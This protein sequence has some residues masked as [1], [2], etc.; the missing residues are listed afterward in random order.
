MSHSFDR[1]CVDA[2]EILLEEIRSHLH[3]DETPPFPKQYSILAV[4]GRGGMG[5]V[6]RA[7]DSTLGR[8]VAL[9]TI[10]TEHRNR[11][12]TQKRFQ[13][14]QQLLAQLAIPG[15]PQ[16]HLTGKTEDH[17][18]FYSMELIQGPTFADVLTDQPFEISLERFISFAR[19]MALVHRQKIAHGDLKPNNLMVTEHGEMRVM[20]W[21]L[22]RN[23]KEPEDN[24]T[25]PDNKR[26][27]SNHGLMGTFSY[28]APEQARGHCHM[29]LS[30][31]VF[32]MGA[33]L[34]EL[35][36]GAPLYASSNR[37]NVLEM[38][39]KG[40]TS[41]MQEKLSGCNAEPGLIQLARKSIEFDPSSRPADAVQFFEELNSVIRQI[42]EK[43]RTAEQELV[44]IEK[45]FELF[46]ANRKFHR[47]LAIAGG[48]A[49]LA[50]M[51]V[52]VGWGA[53]ERNQR[54]VE[55]GL[56]EKAKKSERRAIEGEEH[57]NQSFQNARK[58]YEE[59]ILAASEVY[60]LLDD[61]L[62]ANSKQ[63]DEIRGPVYQIG[64]SLFTDFETT[65]DSHPTSYRKYLLRAR[66]AF[67]NWRLGNTETA[68]EELSQVIR[69]MQ[70]IESPLE[71][72]AFYGA[73][74]D[75]LLDTATCYLELELTDHFESN[76]IAALRYAPKLDSPPLAEARVRHAY[77]MGLFS[78][79][80]MVEAERQLVEAKACL[81]RL[82]KSALKLQ[83]LMYASVL[84][85][86]GAVQEEIGKR[87]ESV[88]YLQKSVE[89]LNGVRQSSISSMRALS[90]A[91]NSLGIYY[92]KSG[93]PQKSSWHF[94][95]A[96]DIREDSITFASDENLNDLA[97]DFNNLGTA[98]VGVDRE[99][100]RQQFAY[101]IRIQR[102]VLHRN[103]NSAKFKETMAR[104]LFNLGDSYGADDQPEKALSDYESA[105]LYVQKNSSSAES[106]R[107]FANILIGEAI[108]FRKLKKTDSARAN[109]LQAIQVLQGLHRPL[110]AGNAYADDLAMAHF[111]LCILEKVTGNLEDAIRHCESAISVWGEFDTD[112]PSI[113]PK[114]NRGE[115]YLRALKRAIQQIKS[116]LSASESFNAHE[117]ARNFSA[118]CNPRKPIDSVR[119]FAK[120]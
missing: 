33:I 100:A 58:I 117:N 90:E 48:I 93:D 85:K 17:H 35:L 84:N 83:T 108:E 68:I 32:S 44:Y 79:G 94:Q 7:F 66:K 18:A 88:K 65:Y 56:K 60:A 46:E 95:Q 1:S 52:L 5:V 31:D 43:R 120:L 29:G 104:L 42:D 67:L 74:V 71:P 63:F 30:L 55:A 110:P 107:L 103:S 101:G 20:D 62:L 10:R 89:L 14:E 81:E 3:E 64:I 69:E 105:K 115:R 77:G 12:S 2:N 26:K 82:P 9:K 49:G 34:C 53:L 51:A 109:Y 8:E 112:N 47:M 73:L 27:S 13:Y 45:D 96:V 70:S 41:A 38:A 40:D 57:A 50:I 24:H 99:Q 19:T 97:I 78:L 75:T 23:L 76:M 113:A 80:Q 114:L 11:I 102:R 92:E 59:A 16:I 91:H 116:E 15:I 106:R 119:E 54:I 22:A 36:T 61:P 98:L 39:R 86:L 4:L 37:E 118:D 111:N 6:Y 72:N 21:G 28:M 87:N 25:L